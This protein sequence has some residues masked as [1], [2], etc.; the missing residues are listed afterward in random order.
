MIPAGRRAI[1]TAG[2]ARIRGVTLGA[3]NNAKP[4]D[5]EDF[6][7]QLNPGTRTGRLWDEE[8]VRAHTDTGRFLP[9]PAVEPHP[10]DLLDDREAAA[11]VGVAES[12]WMTAIKKRLPLVSGETPTDVHGVRHWPRATLDRISARR[13]PAG[14]PAGATDRA[15]RKRRTQDPTPEA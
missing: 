6:P 1:N 5:A 15:P 13:R 14:R 8:Q 4:Y 11:Y 3:L 2:V 10:D 12:T 9:L 7:P